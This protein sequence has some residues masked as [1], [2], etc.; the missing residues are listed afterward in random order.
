MLMTQSQRYNGYIAGKPEGASASGKS[1]MQPLLPML[2]NKVSRLTND[3]KFGYTTID[4]AIV[5]AKE[6]LARLGQLS[7]YKHPLV[8]RRGRKEV[9]DVVDVDE[10]SKTVKAGSKTYFLDI[11]KTKDGKPFLVITESR[12]KGEGEERERSSIVVFQESAQEFGDSV[13][14]MVKRLE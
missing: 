10:N 11:R 3:P 1:W 14:E 13:S 8:V 12:F 4:D 5:L 2:D 9:V 7:E 6:L